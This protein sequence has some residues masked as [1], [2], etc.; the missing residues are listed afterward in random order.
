[1]LIEDLVFYPTGFRYIKG[2][3]SNIEFVHKIVPASY[4]IHAT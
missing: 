1:M 3:L 4:V 2:N